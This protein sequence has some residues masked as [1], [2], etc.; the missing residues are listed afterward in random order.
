[1]KI[2][3]LLPLSKFGW[4]FSFLGISAFSTGFRRIICCLTAKFKA[5]L[6]N[7]QGGGKV[8]EDYYNVTDEQQAIQADSKRMMKK[9]QMLLK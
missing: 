6:V 2:F 7:G 1:M 5:F 3:L 9:R 8:T 4:F